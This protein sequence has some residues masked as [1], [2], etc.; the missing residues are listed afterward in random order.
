MQVKYLKI[1]WDADLGGFMLDANAYLEQI[2]GMRQALPPGA[3]D[4]VSAEGHYNMGS[5]TCV[6][7]LELTAIDVPARKDGVLTLEFAP[8]QWKHESGL[9]IRYTE[10]SHLAIEYHR[11]IDWMNHDTVLLDEILPH[12]TGCH[13][14]I[15]LTD[16]TI[17]IHSKDLHATWT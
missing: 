1:D 10:V 5:S 8:N 6:K 12:D 9:L 4:F 16:S 11:S 14:E 15:A 2:P 17:T 3:W 13:H 7:D